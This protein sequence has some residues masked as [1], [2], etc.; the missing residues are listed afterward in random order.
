M[1]A[2]ETSWPAETAEPL[3]VRVPA[4]VMEAVSTAELNAVDPPLVEVST[5][6]PLVP[7]VWSQARKVMAGS[8][9]PLKSAAGWNR[10]LAVGASS[11]E[12]EFETDPTGFQVVPPSVEYCQV[13]LAELVAVMAMPC[14]A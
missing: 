8:T 1:S 14:R 13:P 11:R 7:E 12:L 10:I 6:V 3:L 9:V 4:T 5:L 2:A